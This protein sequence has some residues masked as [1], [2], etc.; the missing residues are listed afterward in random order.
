M[1]RHKV[2]K[3]IALW[4]YI[5]FYKNN[6]DTQIWDLV[7]NRKNGVKADIPTDGFVRQLLSSLLI[8]LKISHL[9]ILIRWTFSVRL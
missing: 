3:V 9:Q 6:P 8:N 2:T 1:L 7:S 5:I 4:F